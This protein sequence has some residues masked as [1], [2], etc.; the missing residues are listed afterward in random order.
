[1]SPTAQTEAGSAVQTR[2]S[3]R[4][5]TD[6][7]N[8]LHVEE[9][10]PREVLALAVHVERAGARRFRTFADAFRD[11][12]D[13]VTQQ[14]EELAREKDAHEWK[15]VQAFHRHFGDS[16]PSVHCA[17]VDAVI[18]SPDPGG[19]EH[20]MPSAAALRRVYEL[21]LRAEQCVR[22]FYLHAA[23]TCSDAYVAALYRDLSSMVDKHVSWCE[24]KIHGVEEP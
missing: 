7:P 20:G 1:M 9:L 23:D 24:K 10:A 14:C 15:L 8:A 2:D 17:D 3:E 21:A 12:D 5:A 13:V 11:H 6:G 16:L 22:T 4:N 19:T 18:L